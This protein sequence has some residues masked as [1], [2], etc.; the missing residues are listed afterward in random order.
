M[1]TLILALIVA[2]IAL[3]SH[4]QEM[5][6]QLD[7]LKAAQDEYDE[8]QM[9]KARDEAERERQLEENRQAERRA[10]QRLAEERRRE[11]A[12]RAEA[13]RQEKLKDKARLQAMEDE[14]HALDMDYKRAK[15]GETKAMS[16]ARSQR[17]NDYVDAEL[18]KKKAETDV[19][20]SEADAKRNVSEGMKELQTGAGKG[21]E[22]AGRGVEAEGNSWFK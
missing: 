15:V 7:R 10:A 3:P 22:A 2:S 9:Q 20:Q 8:A 17:A 4:A 19:V 5:R 13:E 16:A 18:A 21:L 12:A 11:A 14:E 6:E 1:K